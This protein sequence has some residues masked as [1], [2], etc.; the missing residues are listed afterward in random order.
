MINGGGAIGAD[1][2]ARE[3]AGV[4]IFVDKAGIG[5]P[6]AAVVELA[7]AEEARPP[8]AED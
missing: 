1:D 6:S 4:S 8:D 2:A 7:C 5:W 3:E